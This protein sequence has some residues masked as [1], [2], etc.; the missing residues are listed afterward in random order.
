MNTSRRMKKW[1]VVK[2]LTPKQKGEILERV[3]KQYELFRYFNG[4]YKILRQADGGL[5][6]YILR[7]CPHCGYIDIRAARPLELP[8]SCIECGEFSEVS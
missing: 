2:R 4:V 7:R 3:G 1:K 8:V 6:D 5:S